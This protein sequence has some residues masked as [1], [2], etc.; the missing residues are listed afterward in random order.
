MNPPFS[1]LVVYALAIAGAVAPIGT[2]G[3]TLY[4]CADSDGKVSYQSSACVAS[5]E[6]SQK[7]L[8][9]T[10]QDAMVGVNDPTASVTVYPQSNGAYYTMAS[11]NGYPTQIM[12][13]T[14]ASTVAIPVALANRMGLKCGAIVV[15]NGSAGDSTGCWTRIDTLK[16]GA[17]TLTHVDAILLPNLT[18]GPLLGQTAL[19]R[20]KV[21]QAA[22]VIKL[23][24]LVGRT[25]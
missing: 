19:K 22:D 15:T 12:I 4:K 9:Y 20:L 21:E 7:P 13:D 2:T 17:I 14:G 10:A 24:V 5:K 23:G 11:I 16:I 18:S 25:R 8:K 6:V 3:E 1:S